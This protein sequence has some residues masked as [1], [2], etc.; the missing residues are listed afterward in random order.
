MFSSS[1]PSFQCTPGHNPEREVMAGGQMPSVRVDK[2]PTVSTRVLCPIW[3]TSPA[4]TMELSPNNLL[5]WENSLTQFTRDAVW[6]C[7]P[8]MGPAVSQTW[9]Q[10]LAQAV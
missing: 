7:E 4:L 10:I 3:M 6:P 8:D 2:L 9:V 5:L 1:A